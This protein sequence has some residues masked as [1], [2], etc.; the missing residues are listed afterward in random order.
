MLRAKLS[1]QYLRSCSSCSTH[2]NKN[3]VFSP[4]IFFTRCHLKLYYRS[5]RLIGIIRLVFFFFASTFKSIVNCLP[6]TPRFMQRKKI[7]IKSKKN[8]H[9]TDKLPYFKCHWIN[10]SLVCRRLRSTIKPKHCWL[11]F[12]ATCTERNIF[13]KCMFSVSKISDQ[14]PP[15]VSFYNLGG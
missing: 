8:Q 6:L 15:P 5:S 10:E 13:A 7:K 2:R 12:T 11:Q 4:N 9:K 1:R 14:F 3:S